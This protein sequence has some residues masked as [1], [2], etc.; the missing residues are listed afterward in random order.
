MKF[1]ARFP[2]DVTRILTFDLWLVGRGSY[3]TAY[4]LLKCINVGNPIIKNI[5][6]NNKDEIVKFTYE[7]FK[8]YYENM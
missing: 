4:K 6:K 8:K 1:V 7:N 5:T 3:K 2:G